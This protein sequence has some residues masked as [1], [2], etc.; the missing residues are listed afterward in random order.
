MMGN[1]NI[2]I[3]AVNFVIVAAFSFCLFLVVTYI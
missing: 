2:P 1:P 3:G